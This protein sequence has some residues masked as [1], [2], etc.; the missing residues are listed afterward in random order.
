V[1][2]NLRAYG[3]FSHRHTPEVTDHTGIASEDIVFTTHLLPV[4]RG[5]LSTLYVW[6]AE[7]HTA[8]EVE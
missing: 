2:E 7:P 1:D 4:A 6:F 3:L 8:A 5:I